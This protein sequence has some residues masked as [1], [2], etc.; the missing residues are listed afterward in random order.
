MKKRSQLLLFAAFI[1][2][3]LMTV[4]LA[5]TDTFASS[6]RIKSDCYYCI[7]SGNTVYCEDGGKVFKVD[8]ITRKAT[9]LKKIDCGA[10][11]KKGKYLYFKTISM[12]DIRKSYI[13]RLD[14]KTGK[15]KY[16]T[17]ALN[18]SGEHSFSIKGKYIYY[19]YCTSS[20][21]IKYMKMR[22]NGKGKH[23]TSYR[24]T[25][26]CKQANVKGYSINFSYKSTWFGVGPYNYYLMTP[27][28]NILLE[29]RQEGPYII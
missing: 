17:K 3:L 11:I 1:L 29:S 26:K 13:Y 19:E 2:T 10:M 25:G 23:K 8:L 21:N 12:K 5:A 22:L 4:N 28:G 14:T 20:G 15:G 6:K 16:L 24:P 9:L 7:K 27:M 18:T